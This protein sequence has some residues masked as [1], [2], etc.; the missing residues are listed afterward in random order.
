M[1]VLLSGTTIAGN[2]ALHLGNYSTYVPSL[3][4][5]G[6]SGTWSISITGNAANVTGTVAVA[7]GGT[8]STT[9]AGARTNLGA[10]TAGSNLFTLTNPS[11][12]T[13]LRINADNTVTALDAASFRTAIGAGTLST[14]TDTL[15]TVTGRGSTTS[16]SITVGSITAN[17]TLEVG[18]QTAVQGGASI[19]Q[20][21]GTGDYIGSIGSEYGS[22][23]MILGYGATGKTGAA[24]FV[25]TF[26]NFS[27]IR[28]AIEI[29]PGTFSVFSSTNA[30]QTTT[31]SDLTMTE[32]FR[33][34]AA[35]NV[36]IGLG[37]TAPTYKLDVSGTVRLQSAASTLILNNSTYS[38]L[39]YGATNYF[40]ANGAAALINGPSIQFLVGGSEYGR[41]AATTG[42]L[43]LGTTTDSTYKLDVNGTARVQTTFQVGTANSASG[44]LRV[45]RSNGNTGFIIQGSSGNI[46]G[47]G[48]APVWQ[49]YN[50]S[51][52]S[53]NF[54]IGHASLGNFN[55]YA[56][57][58]QTVTSN[59]HLM[60]LTRGG[61]L[62]IGTQTDGGYKLDVNGTAR[63]QSTLQLNGA[64]TIASTLNVTGNTTLGTSIVR[65]YRQWT[66]GVPSNNLGD[67]TVTEMALFDEQFDNKTAFFDTTKIVIE[68]FD[69]TTWTDVT[70]SITE[71]N[72]RK[73]VGGDAVDGGFTIPYGTQQYRITFDNNGYV[74]LNA[75]YSYWSSNG[76]NS[77][78]HIWKKHNSGSWEQHTN[79]TALVNAWPG[80]LYLPFNTIPW[81]PTGTLGQ[82]Y[83]QVRIVFIPSWNSS[84]S[85]NGITVSKM[86]LWGGY[87]ASKRVVYTTNETRGVTFPSTLSANSL[88]VVNTI[89]ASGGSSTDWNT[90]YSERNRWDGGATGLTAST[91]RTSLGATTVGSNLFTLTNPSA[92]TFLRINADNTVSTLDA[93]TFRTAIGAG[94]S[95]TTGTV[96]SITAGTGLS[97]GT[98]TSSGTIALA[99]TTVTPG[100]YTLASITV[101]AQGRI[102]AA[103]SG[104]AGGTGTVTS[105]AMTVP[106]GLTV[107]GSPIT[108]A[109]TLAVSLQSGYS[110]PT[111]SSQ[112]N[113]DAA[114]NDKINSIAV[115]GTTTKTITLTQQDAGTVSTTFTDRDTTY[116]IEAEELPPG[117]F[118]EVRLRD[119]GAGIS[120]FNMIG[121]GATTITSDQS[122]NVYFNSTDTNTTYTAGAGI[123]LTGTQFTHTDTSSQPSVDNS[124][125]TVI[126]DVTLDTYGHVTSL[127]SVD[128]DGRYYTETEHDSIIT[129]SIRTNVNLTGGGLITVSS[130]NY[131]K[132]STRF[133][134]I[135]NGRGS[136]F[137]TAGYF[138]ITCPTSGT[139]TGVSGANNRTATTDGIQLN[140]WESLYYILPLGSSNTSVAANFRVVGYSTDVNIPHNWILLCVRNGDNGVFSFPR[141]INL[142]AGDSSASYET[143]TNVAHTIVSRDGNGNFSAGTITAGGL[144]V[145]TNTL[146]V[147]TTNDRVG[148]GTTAPSYKLH[149]T[150]DI[151]LSGNLVPTGGSQTLGT[152]ANRFGDIWAGGLIVGT[153]FYGDNVQTASGTLA[154]KDS[155]GVEKIRMTNGGNLLIGTATDGGY[156]LDVNGTVR[157]QS[158][159]L[160]NGDATMSSLSFGSTT[161]QMLNL[162]STSYGAGVQSNTQYFRTASRFS[163]FRGGTHSN[164]ENTAGS[165]GTVAMTLDSS[166]NLVV[167][168]DVTAYSDARFKENVA[169]IENALD[170]VLSLEGVTYT[171]KDDPT[172]TQKMGFIAQQ[173]KEI[174]PEVVTIDQD[175]NSDIPDKHSVAYGNVVALL[176]EA[177]KEQQKQIDDLKKRLGE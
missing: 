163:W 104:S 5:S 100:S 15:N 67:P 74:F 64:V 127:G 88:S 176:V 49:P 78:V 113:W 98:I 12:V 108:G 87:P 76:H 166:S 97:G 157:L 118:V 31:G 114:Y 23:A 128:L 155:G 130:T 39:N 77:Q 94:T 95:S 142:L 3:T 109:G 111:T 79:S 173:V 41:F 46:L 175:W 162:Y 131:V 90:A 154:F 38:E 129:P 2:V 122:G 106:T 144:T 19:Y 177:I 34:D 35:G 146:H 16:N 18:S 75:L 134:M 92:V 159:L 4:G 102:T 172:S 14:E 52:A 55:W 110:I 89:T 21:Y 11:A 61:N 50:Y 93:A 153:T 83:N 40:R 7:N 45:E 47:A 139:I 65:T 58:S 20:K 135:N 56:G 174:I 132:W 85:G 28:G 24:G 13:F 9:A 44:T 121:T 22:G 70:A 120:L 30:V 27:G 48:A 149:V 43:L 71:T 107:S 66:D 171:R 6:A 117:N 124:N 112:A 26:D 1:A 101:D 152:F 133:I 33:V 116:T 53:N 29:G 54:N 59:T 147:D 96:T 138:D 115:T 51:D 68:S 62:L 32:T 72:R 140:L 8:G 141:G 126:Q 150:G 168:G 158:T 167:T 148:V 105:V 161:S 145:D 81:H 60:Q 86:Q 143:N 123:T 151:G 73:L 164:T 160:V 156:K 36:G 37:S 137:S 17:G 10:T 80:H 136:G 165:G 63:I 57:G 170:K 82:H 91:G 84:F 125:G 69:G 25:S 42:N 119:S 99:N 103:S 169:P